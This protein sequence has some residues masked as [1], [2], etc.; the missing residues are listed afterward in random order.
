[1]WTNQMLEIVSGLKYTL[2]LGS[3]YPNDS[4]IRSSFINYLYLINHI[5]SGDVVILHDRK[6][7]I[8]I[9]Y[10]LIPWLEKNNYR[11]MT[12]EELFYKELSL[13]NI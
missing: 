4:A 11:T 12:L 9:I 10:R 1:M 3:I 8:P 7:T 2:V 5:E 13:S 6:W